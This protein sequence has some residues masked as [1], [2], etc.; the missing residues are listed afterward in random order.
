MTNT[1]SKL[2]AQYTGDASDGLLTQLTQSHGMNPIDSGLIRLNMP[3]QRDPFMRK[4]AILGQ[5]KEQSFY[6]Y[7]M[8]FPKSNDNW[9]KFDFR[10]LWIQLS[11][12]SI[13]GNDQYIMQSWNIIGSNDHKTWTL[14]D[15]VRDAKITK[16]GHWRTF[17]CTRN[18]GPFRYIRY[19]Q[20][21]NSERD[22]KCQYFI[23][24][25]GLEFFGSLVESNQ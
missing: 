1:T 5:W 24:I 22:E 2:V 8:T 21:A 4:S 3:T 25:S 14:I 12:Y 18:A 16:D 9:V 11:A 15:L 20:H 10:N 7:A 13:R 6:N 19:V 17:V 23:Q